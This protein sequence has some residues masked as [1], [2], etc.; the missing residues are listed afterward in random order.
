[1]RYQISCFECD[2]EYAIEYE[3][4]LIADEPQFCMI[5]KEPITL[6]PIDEQDI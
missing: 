1:M 5:C 6:E 3:E 2:S 4:G